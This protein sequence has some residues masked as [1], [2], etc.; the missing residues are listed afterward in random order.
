MSEEAL[1]KLPDLIEPWFFFSLIWSI[2]ASCD[3]DG[4]VKFSD[5]LRKK[6]EKYGI[7]MNIPAEGLVYDYVIDDGG[8]FAE[9]EN[10]EE[11]NEEEGKK[12]KAV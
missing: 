8:I 4:R 3:N 5:W 10:K 1:Q 2:G 12:V 11:G 6:I 9:E 7:K